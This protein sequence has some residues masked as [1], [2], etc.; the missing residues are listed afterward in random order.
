MVLLL[1][2]SFWLVNNTFASLSETTKDKY[3]QVI[4]KKIFDKIET[5][6]IDTQIKLL[7]NY[8]SKFN[9]LL[10]KK[11]L[12]SNTKEAISFI[13]E[14][15]EKKVDELNQEKLTWIESIN[16]K[17]LND[18]NNN[19]NSKE[20]R[21]ETISLLR[22]ISQNSI[23]NRYGDDNLDDIY[24]LIWNK[25]GIDW[26]NINWDYKFNATLSYYWLT[27][28][29]TFKNYLENNIESKDVY[30]YKVEDWKIIV[31]E[32]EISSLDIQ[33]AVKENWIYNKEWELIKILFKVT[34]IWTFTETNK[35]QN[36][37]NE[38]Y[39]KL[40]IY[41]IETDTIKDFYQWI[42]YSSKINDDY[43]IL[44]NS[45]E[46]FLVKID[47]DLETSNTYKIID[48]ETEE[49]LFSQ[50]AKY[51][52]FRMKITARLDLNKSYIF[53]NIDNNLFDKEI[54]DNDRFSY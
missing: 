37:H 38:W 22:N 32:K 54:I 49:E 6:T 51:N 41:D 34:N 50:D 25:N 30:S 1:I 45:L 33:K 13:N 42:I 52:Q 44:E 21:N 46:R 10:S 18:F 16:S 40:L 36:F 24:N 23:N 35:F 31:N 47:D 20:F 12:N 11:N 3:E 29:S 9:T 48:S 39:I 15:F 4:E 7:N 8:I 19:I 5:K 14:L 28:L 53:K 26:Y 2:S 17:K 27:N 43:V